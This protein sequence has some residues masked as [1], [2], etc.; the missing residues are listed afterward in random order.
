[1]AVVGVQALTTGAFTGHD[2]GYTCKGE[3]EWMGRLVTFV[4]ID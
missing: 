2:F 4:L 3:L 1:M